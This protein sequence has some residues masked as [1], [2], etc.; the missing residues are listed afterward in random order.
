MDKTHWRQINIAYPGDNPEQREQQAVTHLAQVLPASEDSGLI[1]TWWYLRKGPWRIRYTPTTTC[2]DTD[3]IRQL[4][5]QTHPWTSDIYEPETHAFGGTE[6]MQVAHALFHHDSR[7]LLTY[8][9]PRPSD[10]RERSLILCTALMRSAGL[11]LDEQGDV[12][13][14]VANARAAAH[15]RLPPTDSDVW[16]A[17]TDN[18]RHL[19]LGISHTDELSRTWHTAFETAGASLRALR[20]AGK[21]TRGLRAAIAKHVIFHWNRIG[22]PAADQA[23]LAHAATEAIFGREQRVVSL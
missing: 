6:A 13:A 16:K 11:D 19:L 23:A 1:T 9:H 22:I 20:E 4:L 17:F 7:H 15:N 18:V 2:H 3:P 10:R 21:L 8:L 12:W 14:K 5:T